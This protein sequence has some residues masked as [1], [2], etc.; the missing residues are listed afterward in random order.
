MLTDQLPSAKREGAGRDAS[1]IR[2]EF[3]NEGLKIY[4]A[5]QIGVF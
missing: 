2:P 1:K 5:G 3:R 4:I